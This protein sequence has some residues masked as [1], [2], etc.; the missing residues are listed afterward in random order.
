MST[1]DRSI[2]TS[3]P[4]VLRY[5]PY[6]L[7]YLFFRIRPLFIFIHSFFTPVYLFASLPPG[8]AP[9]YYTLALSHSLAQHNSRKLTLERLFYSVAVSNTACPRPF[10][11]SCRVRPIGLAGTFLI[12]ISTSTSPTQSCPRVITTP[13]PSLPFHCPITRLFHFPSCFHPPTPSCVP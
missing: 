1:I 10:S 7:P 9:H 11:W 13:F 5:S 2:S 8:P 12:L 4:P 6:M 3:S